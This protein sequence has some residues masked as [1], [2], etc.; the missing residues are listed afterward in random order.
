M[1]DQA[2]ERERGR[3]SEKRK[4]VVLVNAA[5]LLKIKK[6]IYM[7]FHLLTN[8]LTNQLRLYRNLALCS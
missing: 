2:E 1:R 6:K 7:M 3:K 5:T 8:A 4:T